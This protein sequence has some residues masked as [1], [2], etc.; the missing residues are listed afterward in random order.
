MRWSD[1]P[2]SAQRVYRPR[3]AAASRDRATSVP[4]IWAGCGQWC[5]RSMIAS[6]YGSSPD[7]RR[8]RYTRWALRGV[9][10]QRIASW[11]ERH[12]TYY[13]LD[14]SIR[15][16]VEYR[17]LNLVLDDY[18]SVVGGTEGFDLVLCRNVM[19]YFDLPTVSRIATGLLASLAPDGWLLLGAS[20]PPLAHLVP[21]EVVVTPAGIAYR[22]ADRAGGG[23]EL[24]APVP[25]LERPRAPEPVPQPVRISESIAPAPSSLEQPA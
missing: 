23:T 21:C 12:G 18:S 8:G 19:I 4:R 1:T 16:S 6:V 2:R 17:S 7:A 5:S 20:D 3:R 24:R 13:D 9:S 10:D 15:E 25:Q 22:R 11:F 14:R